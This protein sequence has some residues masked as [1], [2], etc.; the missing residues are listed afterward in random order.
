MDAG[1]K[2]AAVCSLLPGFVVGTSRRTLDYSR[3]AVPPDDS[4]ADLKAL[5]LRFAP[6]PA[7]ETN[8]AVGPRDSGRLLLVIGA[9]LMFAQV[10]TFGERGVWPSQL[11]RACN[12]LFVGPF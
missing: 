8:F 4:K 6:P 10:M 12:L 5:A 9:T 7:P 2:R 11:R 3:L 1:M